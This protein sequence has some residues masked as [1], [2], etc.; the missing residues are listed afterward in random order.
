MKE[1]FGINGSICVPEQNSSIN[2]SKPNLK[3]GLSLHYNADNSY[4]FV[5]GRK[6]LSLNFVSEVYLKDSAILSL[7]RYL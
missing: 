7:E 5:D 3:F 1:I 2:F 6:S 4:L